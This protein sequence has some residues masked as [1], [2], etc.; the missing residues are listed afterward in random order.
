MKI[1]ITTVDLPEEVWKQFAI[2]DC[3]WKEKVMT[4]DLSPNVETDN[5]VPFIDVIT[6]KYVS[7]MWKA[8]ADF[9]LV[10]LKAQQESEAEVARQT[11][12]GAERQALL[13]AKEVVMVTTE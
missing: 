9:N 4:T 3:N 10:Q 2:V 12:E 6:E 1:N 8:I 11:L 5:P 7:P 13:A